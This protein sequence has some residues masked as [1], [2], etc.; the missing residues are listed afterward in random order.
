MLMRLTMALRAYGQRRVAGF[1]PARRISWSSLVPKALIIDGR[2]TEID[3]RRQ[4]T[5][6]QQAPFWRRDGHTDKYLLCRVERECI[7]L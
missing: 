1:M 3:L 5:A 7:Y 6:Y 4:L 2:Y